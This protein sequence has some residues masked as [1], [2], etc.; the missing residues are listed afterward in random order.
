VL[1]W[2]HKICLDYEDRRDVAI[3]ILRDKFV[4]RTSAHYCD[5][6]DERKRKRTEV[7]AIYKR[8]EQQDLIRELASDLEDQNRVRRLF[9]GLSRVSQMCFGCIWG[10][11]IVT[12]AGLLSTWV[13]VPPWLVVVWA[14]ALGAGL[15]AFFASVSVLWYLDGRFFCLVNRIIEPEGE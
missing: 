9:R 11:I 3:N 8:R 12:A 15:I 5:V 4:Q 7:E 1:N 13:P 14:A 6:A 2:R 10:S